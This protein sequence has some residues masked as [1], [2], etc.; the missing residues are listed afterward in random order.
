MFNTV[1]RST[2]HRTDDTDLVK[3][4]LPLCLVTDHNMKA[5]G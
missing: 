5:Y 4:K 2:L 1:R 3:S